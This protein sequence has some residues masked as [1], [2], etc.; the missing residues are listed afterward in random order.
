MNREI[1]SVVFL[2]LIEVQSDAFI[3]FKMDMTRLP[4]PNGDRVQIVMSG[5]CLACKTYW[6]GRLDVAG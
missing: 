2:F 4:D 6:H 5:K 3:D 1:G